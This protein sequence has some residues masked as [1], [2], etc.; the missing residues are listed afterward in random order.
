V[1]LRNTTFKGTIICDAN[2]TDT[3]FDQ[4]TFKGATVFKAYYSDNGLWTAANIDGNIVDDAQA[5]KE[6]QNYQ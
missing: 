6:C 1:D 4:D 5:P 3:T 2:L